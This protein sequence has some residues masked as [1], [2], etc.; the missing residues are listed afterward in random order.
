MQF[1]EIEKYKLNSLSDEIIIPNDTHSSICSL[2]IAHGNN[3]KIHENLT[4]GFFLLLGLCAQNRI[5]G[6]HVNDLLGLA[7]EITIIRIQKKVAQKIIGINQKML[8]K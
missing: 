3:N 8:N 5:H 6:V 2:K 1:I 4:A 7:K